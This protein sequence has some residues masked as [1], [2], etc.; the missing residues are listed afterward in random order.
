MNSFQNKKI[1]F[2]ETGQVKEGVSADMYS[3]VKDKSIDLAIVTVS[4]DAKTLLQKIVKGKKTIEGYVSG[5]GILEVTSVDG[6]VVTHQFSDG[7]SGEVEVNIGELMQW[8]NLGASDLV[9]YEICDPPYKEG[10]FKNLKED[11]KEI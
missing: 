8:T 7:D 4:K 1:S 9:F 10:R 5:N 3:F 6:K 11:N 2:I